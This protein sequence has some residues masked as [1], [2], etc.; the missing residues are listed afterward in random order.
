MNEKLLLARYCHE[1]LVKYG[2]GCS[3]KPDLSIIYFWMVGKSLEEENEF[4]KQLLKHVHQDGTSFLSSTYV[5]KRFVIRVAVLSFR[6]KLNTID[7]TIEM[8]LRAK[9]KLVLGE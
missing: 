9:K 7:Q 8:L 3:P 1:E 4:T 6:T 2:F 5:K